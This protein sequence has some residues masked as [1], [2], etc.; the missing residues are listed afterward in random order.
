MVLILVGLLVLAAGIHFRRAN[1]TP[2]D[3]RPLPG[4]VVDVSVKK[5]NFSGSR[6]LLY[7]PSVEYSD[8]VTG[9]SRVLPP[10]SHQPRERKI[11]DTV[12]L[13]RDPATGEVRLPLANPRSQMLLPFVFSA[14]MIA[15]GVADLRG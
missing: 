14:L 2:A 4:R 1:R 13:V 6:T 8:P 9:Q 11:G 10:A 7:G 3:A 15:L 12:T 5:S